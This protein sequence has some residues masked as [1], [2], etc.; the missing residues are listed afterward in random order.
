MGI[1]SGLVADSV[2]H[3]EYA[4]C[5]L[6]MKFLTDRVRTF[7]LIETVLYDR[8][9]AA[10]SGE[11]GFAYLAGHLK[12]LETSARYFGFRY[13]EG[14]VRAALAAKAAGEGS[15]RQR[16]RL[17]LAEDGAITVAST[18]LGAADPS[19]VMTYVVSPTRLKSGDLYLFHK[20]TERQLYDQEWAH[21]HETM[22]ADEVIYLNEAGEVCEGSRTSIFVMRDGTLLTP[23][24]SAGLLPGVLRAE[25]LASG[26]AVEA[27]LTLADLEGAQ[28][29]LGNS[30][31]GLVRAEAL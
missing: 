12:R 31:R 13:D 15:V 3:R 23:A 29:Y 27:R 2:G 25:L 5:L 30:V 8:S 20:T 1:G 21:Y 4:E 14:A 10:L 11:G 9:D 22:G 18:A 7:S 24:L 6:K 26:Q 19:T 28:V 16:V 17:L